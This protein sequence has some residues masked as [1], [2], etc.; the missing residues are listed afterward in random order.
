ME[1]KIKT[2]KPGGLFSSDKFRFALVEVEFGSPMKN[3]LNY[4]ICR[5][6]VL[7]ASSQDRC[8]CRCLA[9]VRAYEGGL[10]QFVFDKKSMTASTVEKHF[11][12]GLFR[13]T[14]AYVLVSEV[15]AKI[16]RES[17][18]VLPGIYSV[19]EEEGCLKVIF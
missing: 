15:V 1:S 7:A 18:V 14:D 6:N 3:C 11:K 19:L 12:N 4:G 16:G 13:V 2:L 5:V 10:V 17:F 8:P 9:T